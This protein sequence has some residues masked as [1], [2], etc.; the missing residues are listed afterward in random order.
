ME[1]PGTGGSGV[2]AFP[3]PGAHRRGKKWSAW[4][5]PCMARWA[6]KASTSTTGSGS[7]SSGLAQCSMAFGIRIPPGHMTPCVCV[8]ALSESALLSAAELRPFLWGRQQTRGLAIVRDY[9]HLYAMGHLKR[10]SAL[11]YYEPSGWFSRTPSNILSISPASRLEHTGV[12]CRG[13]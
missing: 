1:R 10:W 6:T 4:P 11:Y 13:I 7:T 12:P 2:K 5:F 8:R 3:L 9:S